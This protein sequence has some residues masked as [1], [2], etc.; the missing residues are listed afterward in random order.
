[1]NI[2]ELWKTIL[3]KGGEVFYTK[4]KLPFKYFKSDSNHVKIYRDGNPVGLVAKSDI[5]FI[6]NNPYELR[7][8]YRDKMRTASYALA[9]VDTLTDLNCL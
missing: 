3:N 2:D 6:L 1:M 4:T 5:D 8:V 7:Y 9:I